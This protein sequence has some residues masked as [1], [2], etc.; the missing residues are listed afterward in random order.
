MIPHVCVLQIR[1]SAGFASAGQS[2]SDS[3]EQTTDWNCNPPPQV[4]EHSPNPVSI[5]NAHNKRWQIDHKHCKKNFFLTFICFPKGECTY[6]FILIFEKGVNF[7]DFV[8]YDD[9]C[10]K[11][12]DPKLSLSNVKICISISDD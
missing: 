7:R 11:I 10:R 5:Q 4:T 1:E 12:L 3:V 6:Y 8:L 9:W 2:A